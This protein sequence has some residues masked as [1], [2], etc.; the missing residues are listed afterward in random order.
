MNGIV[1]MAAVWAFVYLTYVIL[2]PERL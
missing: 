2:Q 1:V